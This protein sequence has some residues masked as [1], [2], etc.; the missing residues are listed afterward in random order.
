[1]FQD[2]NTKDPHE[3]LVEK[4]GA[5]AAKASKPGHIYM[6]AMG[7][8]MGQSCLQVSK[9][10]FFLETNCLLKID[11]N[12]VLPFQHSNSIWSQEAPYD[13]MSSMN[14]W[15]DIS[16]QS[17]FKSWFPLI[18]QNKMVAFTQCNNLNTYVSMLNIIFFV[19]IFYSLHFKLVIWRKLW[20]CMINW[21]PYVQ[22]CLQLRPR[23]RFQKVRYLI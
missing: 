19:S 3:I 4:Y 21:H 6:D 23:T 14:F 8:G 13:E 7:F 1:M 15:A 22:L 11:S 18:I 9:A 17:I 12:L 16:I 10:K 5:E 20:V 2:D